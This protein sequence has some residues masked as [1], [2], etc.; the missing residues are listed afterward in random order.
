MEISIHHR[1]Q[2]YIL[3]QPLDFMFPHDVSGSERN[4]LYWVLYVK[5]AQFTANM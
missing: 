5:V 2:H 3:L 4:P 1:D